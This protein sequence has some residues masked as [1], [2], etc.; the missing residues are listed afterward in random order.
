M[1]PFIRK[2]S[3]SSHINNNL[4]LNNIEDIDL[5]IDEFKEKR[6]RF[7]G[8]G[9]RKRL[10]L[11]LVKEEGLC[12]INN[13]IKK[14]EPLVPVEKYNLKKNKIVKKKSISPDECN[15]KIVNI[16]K[17]KDEEDKDNCCMCHK[18]FKIFNNDD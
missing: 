5:E 13:L 14:F 17:E 2:I 9:K 1:K 11:T 4:D 12:D 10:S 8:K 6:V 18:C 16:K 7:L 15:L 3:S